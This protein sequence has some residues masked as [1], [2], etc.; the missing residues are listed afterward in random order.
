MGPPS[1]LRFRDS[2]GTGSTFLCPQHAGLVPTFPLP[3]FSPALAP[4]G[5]VLGALPPLSAS[6]QVSSP[7][8]L[9]VCSLYPTHTPPRHAFLEDK[10]GVLTLASGPEQSV[11]WRG[12]GGGGVCVAA[13]RRTQPWGTRLWPYPSPCPTARLRNGESIRGSSPPPRSR[14][15]AARGRGERRRVGTSRRGRLE[16]GWVRRGGPRQA[17]PVPPPRAPGIDC[18]RRGDALSPRT[19]LSAEKSCPRKQVKTGTAGCAALAGPPGAARRGCGC[20]PNSP[21]PVA[22]KSLTGLRPKGVPL[23][24]PPSPNG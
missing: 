23:S 9:R 17:G 10:P 18:A 20:L 8:V 22:L 11:L 7:S 6:S 2:A 13:S 5:T 19:G 16:Q 4:P 3:H 14:G 12:G 24:V 21:P 1:C 15:R